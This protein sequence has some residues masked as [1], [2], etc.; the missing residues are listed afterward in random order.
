MNSK[1][2]KA[3]LHVATARALDDGTSQP[4]VSPYLGSAGNFRVGRRAGAGGSP[5]MTPQAVAERC[6]R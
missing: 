4:L 2:E 3:W 1:P 6:R 5:P